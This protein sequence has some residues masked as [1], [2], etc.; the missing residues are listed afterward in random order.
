VDQASQTVP[1]VPAQPTT[2]GPAAG[3]LKVPKPT[4]KTGKRK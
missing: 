1:M 4:S 2:E 3:D